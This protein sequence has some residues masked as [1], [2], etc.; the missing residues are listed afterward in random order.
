MTTLEELIERPVNPG[1][2]NENKVKY[3]DMLIGAIQGYQILL[4]GD[5]S[6]IAAGADEEASIKELE[7]FILVLCSNYPKRMADSK[8][9]AIGC[10]L[11]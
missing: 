11:A 2:K 9:Y 1:E 4:G 3:T 5:T 7:D 8:A 10:K 6:S